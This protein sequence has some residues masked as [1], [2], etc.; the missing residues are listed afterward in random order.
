M[1]WLASHY[2]KTDVAAYPKKL[3]EIQKL[4]NELKG[5]ISES[6]FNKEGHYFNKFAKMQKE[7]YHKMKSEQKSMK[8]K[9]IAISSTKSILEKIKQ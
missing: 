4:F 2:R 5:K 7:K 9:S 1:D 8:T 6:K 3:E